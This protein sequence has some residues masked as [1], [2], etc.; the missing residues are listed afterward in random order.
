[1]IGT[2]S[3]DYSVLGYVGRTVQVCALVGLAFTLLVLIKSLTNYTR[4]V[5]QLED[6]V[7]SHY[8]SYLAY[9][10]GSSPSSPLSYVFTWHS[11][12]R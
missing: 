1:M 11:R 7:L 9:A 6:E 12:E 4:T 2:D 10:V 8:R 3:F 5:P